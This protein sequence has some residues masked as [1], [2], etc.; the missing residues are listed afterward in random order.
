[1]Q[2]DVA[3]L[4]MA[5]ISWSQV[6]IA[7]IQG[8]WREEPH[9]PSAT[10]VSFPVIYA[11]PASCIYISLLA[12][13]E[14]GFASIST[15]VEPL[16]PKGGEASV[17]NA[18]LHNSLMKVCHLRLYGHHDIAEH[19][20]PTVAYQAPGCLIRRDALFVQTQPSGQR[21][22]FFCSARNGKCEN[23]EGW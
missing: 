2:W 20:Q 7:F 9:S 3:A 13:R 21:H 14:L 11:L 22:E 1:M 8:Y 12:S 6:A 10:S 18:H 4:H 19:K 5:T 16:T 17:R 23:V 15:V